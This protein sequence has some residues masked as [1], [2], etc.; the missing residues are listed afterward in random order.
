MDVKKITLKQL[1]ATLIGLILVIIGLVWFLQGAA[2]LHLCPVL[3]FTDCE[4]VT[5]GSPFWEAGGVIASIMGIGIVY[6]GLRR[7]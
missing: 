1:A 3:C 7:V 5:G 4:C 6:F 2:I